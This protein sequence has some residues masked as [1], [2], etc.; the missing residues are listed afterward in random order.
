VETHTARRNPGARFLN[1]LPHR[2]FRSA[3]FRD[4]LHRQSL[5]RGLT[6]GESFAYGLSGR[7]F[8]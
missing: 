3:R 8:P 1:R 6:A 2:T 5:P 7:A 4:V